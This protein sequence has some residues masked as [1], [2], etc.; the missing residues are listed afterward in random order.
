MI[1]LNTPM[2]TEY[3]KHPDPINKFKS[4]TFIKILIE[5][6]TMKSPRPNLYI[7]IKLRKL[8]IAFEHDDLHCCNLQ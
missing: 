6:N 8:L 3:F 4:S 2:W 1:P 7:I 5:L